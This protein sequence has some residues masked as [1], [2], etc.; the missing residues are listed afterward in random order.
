[1]VISYIRV[2]SSLDE[3]LLSSTKMLPPHS[4][5]PS[6]LD[7]RASLSLFFSILTL[8]LT[9]EDKKDSLYWSGRSH[10]L[11]AA[12]GLTIDP[13]SL[14]IEVLNSLSDVSFLL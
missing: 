14:I 10:L 5:D 1:M 4:R 11:R 13:L 12:N 9:S 8:A 7:Q 2:D 3:L 6:W